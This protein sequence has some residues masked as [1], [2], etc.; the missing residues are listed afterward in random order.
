MDCRQIV[1]AFQSEA[2]AG[3]LMRPNIRRFCYPCILQSFQKTQGQFPIELH[4]AFP[5]S[6]PSAMIRINLQ[7]PSQRGFQNNLLSPHFRD[8]LIMLIQLTAVPTL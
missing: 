2:G 8:L 6:V 3:N 5:K 7:K 1:V 4:T